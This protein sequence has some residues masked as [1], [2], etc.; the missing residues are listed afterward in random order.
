[1]NYNKFKRNSIKDYGYLLMVLIPIFLQ[2]IYILIYYVNT[3]V[4]HDLCFIDLI[5]KNNGENLLKVFWSATDGQFRNFIMTIIQF[6]SYR[7]FSYNHF[8]VIF[9]NLIISLLSLFGLWRIFRSSVN[10]SLPWFIP[11]AWIHLNLMQYNNILSSYSTLVSTMVLG[12]IW[13]IY[14]LSKEKYYNIY[15]AL[16]FFMFSFFSTGAGILIY[17]IGILM[18]VIK[19]SS[20]KSLFTW[21][22]LGLIIILTY[23][24]KF[25][26][27]ENHSL[28]SFLMNYPENII[29]T[30]L[31]IIGLNVSLPL[32]IL[33]SVFAYFGTFLGLLVF[34]FF[35]YTIFK[36]FQIDRMIRKKDSAIWGLLLFGLLTITLISVGKSQYG[37]R[38]SFASRYIPYPSVF[39]IAIYMFILQLRNNTSKLY[40]ITSNLFIVI[41]LFGS[42]MGIFYASYMGNLQRGQRIKQKYVLATYENQTDEA[43]KIIDEGADYVRQVAKA[44]QKENKNIFRHEI[45]INS[46]LHPYEPEKFLENKKQNYASS[47]KISQCFE[48]P[49]DY[50]QNI[51]IRASVN[52]YNDNEYVLIKI[53]NNDSLLVSKKINAKS[54]YSA[55]RIFFELDEPIK[56]MNKEYKIELIDNGE[57]IKI[58]LF[59]SYYNGPYPC[60]GSNLAI[61]NKVI[62]LELNTPK[63][64]ESYYRALVLRDKL[65]KYVKN[66]L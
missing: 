62:G 63:E 48:S 50:I 59:N 7:F 18:L 3:T 26:F 45:K 1:M 29:L 60:N 22:G 30:F 20:Q 54:I 43:L 44:M 9:L 53:M 38:C 49:I 13:S 39:I 42:I 34:V 10:N 36:K 25:P 12:A 23:F 66:L 4:S 2:I 19:K 65:K 24:Y 41:M 21:I 8:L 32:G 57:N 27:S 56:L 64:F 14:F 11:I 15:L 55:G 35:L 58:P 52:E 5:S 61:D 33:G 51:S 16:I 47:K 28:F 37:V 17:P 46:L 40:R 31:N 6:I